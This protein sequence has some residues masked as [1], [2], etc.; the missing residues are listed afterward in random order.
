MVVIHYAIK[1]TVQMA[2]GITQ[3]SRRT[4]DVSGTYNKDL[5]TCKRCLS[6]LEKMEAREKMKTAKDKIIQE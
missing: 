2:C 5:V 3:Y 1:G 6:K 4:S